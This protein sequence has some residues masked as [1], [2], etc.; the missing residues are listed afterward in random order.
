MRGAFL[1]L[2]LALLGCTTLRQNSAMV[3]A[4]ASNWRSVATTDDTKRLRAWR[5]AFTD[6]LALAAKAGHQAQLDAG[7]RL[8]D[9]DAAIGGVPIPN[10]DY[11][12]RTIKLGGQAGMLDY[13]AY[14]FF[15]CRIEADGTV[16]KFTKLTGSQRLVGVIFPDGALRQVLLGTMVL[17]DEARA[18]AY[19]TDEMRDVVAYVEQ[20]EPGRWRLV[21]PR[22]HYELQTD[23]MELIPLGG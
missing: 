5:T 19:G 23:I 16:Q 4:D 11:R 20:V 10:G 21:M 9:P 13:V 17:G 18:F 8:F 3:P 6:A 7:G 2:S 14:P 15:R 22:P 1:F 12:C